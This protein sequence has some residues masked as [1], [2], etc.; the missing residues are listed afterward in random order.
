MKLYKETFF[1]KNFIK[2]SCK[3]HKY[4]NDLLSS[5]KF[6]KLI[7]S[8][9]SSN[10]FESKN[11]DDNKDNSNNCENFSYSNNSNNVFK[12]ISLKSIKKKNHL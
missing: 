4:Y 10:T 9:N 5:N 6:P 3:Y 12:K 2:D 1:S 7:N 11:K 8:R